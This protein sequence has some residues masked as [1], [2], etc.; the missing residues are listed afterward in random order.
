MRLLKSLL[1]F[2]LH[3]N[4]LSKTVMANLVVQ[5]HCPGIMLSTVQKSEVIVMEPFCFIL[6]VK[7]GFAL[8]SFLTLWCLVFTKRSYILEQ[9]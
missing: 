3:G 1:N 8:N 4:I 7:E 9:T 2:S 6:V 5:K